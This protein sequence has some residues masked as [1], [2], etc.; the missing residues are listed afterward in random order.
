MNKLITIVYGI[1]GV[2]SWLK[3][4]YHEFEAREK[5][6]EFKKKLRMSAKTGNTKE[7]QDEISRQRND[8]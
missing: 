6:L 5:L 4:R 1:I 8:L 2:F 7:V 3:Q